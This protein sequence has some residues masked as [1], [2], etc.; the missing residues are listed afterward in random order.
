MKQTLRTMTL[1]AASVALLAACDGRQNAE[2]AKQ[3]GVFG[4]GGLDKTDMG[5]LLGAGGG[6]LL[7]SS[8]G[9][10]GHG[11]GSIT[12]GIIGGI[13]GAGIGH[14]IGASLDRADMQ[15]YQQTS[16]KALETA[17][18]GQTLPWRNPESGHSGSITPKAHYQTSS[19][20]YCREFTQ[21]I[22]VGGRVQSGYGT[23]CRQPDG[24]WQIV[25]Q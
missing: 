24:S 15:Y 11:T 14:E 1:L 2:N 8:I 19:G 18:P 7:G 22:N 17:Q 25:S 12:G 23:A 20:Q 6:A 16:Q 9:G 21:T 5:T 13:L 10:H 3:G 4:G